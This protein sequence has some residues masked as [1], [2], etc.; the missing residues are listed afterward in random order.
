M[1]GKKKMKGKAKRSTLDLP[2]THETGEPLTLVEVR[3]DRVVTTSSLVAQKFGKRNSDVL[4]DIRDLNCSQQFYERN[5]AF[6]V[7]MKSLPQGGATKTEHCIMTKD[8]FT[9]LVMGYTGKQAGQFKEEYIYAFNE[10]EEGL[11]LAVSG[12]LRVDV[13]VDELRAA[14]AS[15]QRLADMEKFR[16][17]DSLK[18]LHFE[19]EQL[20]SDAHQSMLSRMTKQFAEAGNELLAMQREA[21]GKIGSAIDGRLALME[22][23][24]ARG[25]AREAS[26]LGGG[27]G[28]WPR[29]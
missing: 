11:R 21:Y 17:M 19:V 4:R 13:Q 5:F 16:C 20:L 10:M 18:L 24:D 2:S 27:A 15:S 22:R 28:L 9:F 7:E 14:V 26:T 6:V 23:A 8:G 3:E 25:P 1:I 12:G 29:R